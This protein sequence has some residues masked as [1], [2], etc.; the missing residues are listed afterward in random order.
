MKKYNFLIYVL[1]LLYYGSLSNLHS[2]VAQTNP[3]A[4]KSISFMHNND[5]L[6]GWFYMASGEGPFPTIILLQGSVG[7]DGDFLNLGKSLS[8]EG[9]NVMTYNYP[10]SWRS[11]GLKTDRAALESVKSALEFARS[12]STVQ[13]FKIDTSEIILAGHSYGGG[14]ALIAAAIDPGIHR[15]ISI[16]GADLYESANELQQNPEKRQ[17]FQQMVDRLLTNQTVARGTSGKEYLETMLSDKD[18]YNTVKYAE[19]LA[20]KHVLLLTGWLDRFKPIERYTLPLYRALQTNGAPNV[21]IMAFETN[22]EFI[23]AEK[24]MTE[25][26]V[27]WLKEE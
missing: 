8:K 27:K 17:N 9:F 11:E 10:G 19:K 20:Q 23:S 18:R 6:Q 15:V 24:E 13:N 3:V 2:A 25:A 1:I 16:A 7:R 26:I 22:H 5:R 4:P 21:K 12:E 14:M